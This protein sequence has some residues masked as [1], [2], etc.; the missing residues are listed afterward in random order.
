MQILSAI[1][2]V[3]INIYLFSAEK[4]STKVYKVYRFNQ[5]ERNRNDPGPACDRQEKFIHYFQITI[6]LLQKI[7]E[8]KADLIEK[9]INPELILKFLH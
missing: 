2:L 8:R 3:S 4:T 1:Y 7:T 6:D 5:T 9:T